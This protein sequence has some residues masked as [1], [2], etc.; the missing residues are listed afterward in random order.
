M[1]VWTAYSEMIQEIFQVVSHSE[2]SNS[3]TGSIKMSCLASNATS[4]F[5]KG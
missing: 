1:Q 5:L 3:N 2:D 4:F